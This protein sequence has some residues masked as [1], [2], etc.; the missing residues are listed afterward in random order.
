MSYNQ[1]TLK[2]QVSLAL[3]TSKM[4]L[5]FLKDATSL[6]YDKGEGG[7]IYKWFI[8]G[9]DYIQKWLQGNRIDAFV[10]YEE[11]IEPQTPIY[12]GYYNEHKQPREANAYFTCLSVLYFSCKNMIQLDWS[13][14]NNLQYKRFPSDIAEVD[15]NTLQ[16]CL[17]FAQQASK[18][19]EAEKAWQDQIISR[20]LQD[21]STDDPED[22]GEN[23]S[24]AYIEEL[25]G[26]QLPF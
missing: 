25:L 14:G 21:H 6:Q 16:R 11:L 18:N 15:I 8:N 19:P 17:N 10:F 23:I 9:F 1:L 26:E 13:N 3:I 12:N 4:S 24:R 22:F 7:E 2:S 5:L 20:L